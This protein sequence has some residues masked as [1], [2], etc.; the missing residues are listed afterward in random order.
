MGRPLQKAFP[1]MN[2]DDLQD[3]RNDVQERYAYQLA[4][5]DLVFRPYHTLDPAPAGVQFLAAAALRPPAAYSLVAIL[6][7]GDFEDIRPN[8]PYDLRGKG[9]ERLIAFQTDRLYRLDANGAQVLWGAASIPATALRELTGA[10]PEEALFLD[11][12]GGQDRLIPD[13][14]ALDLNPVGVE[15]VILAPKP[16]PGFEVVVIYN[17]QP[18]TIRVTPHELIQAVLDAARAAFGHPPGELA[19]FNDA[20]GEL[21]LGQTVQ[22]AG[23]QPHARLLLRPRVVQ[24]G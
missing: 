17:G 13:D 2:T 22:Q 20:G 8:E 11:V 10:S 15:R 4:V 5:G 19:L 1:I 24:G 16:T 9:V 23:V 12:P 7:S 21:N 14:G 6:P 18:A 3:D